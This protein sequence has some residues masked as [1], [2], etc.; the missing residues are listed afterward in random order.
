M[1]TNCWQFAMRL[2][3]F[4]RKVYSFL[5]VLI[6]QSAGHIIP[7][8]SSTSSLSMPTT[9]VHLPTAT[10]NSLLLAR[11]Q[12][13]VDCSASASRSAT[14]AIR[15]ASQS[16]SQAIQQA[17]QSAIQQ[18]QQATISA[19]NAIRDAQNT[20]SQSV[21]QASRSSS[22]IASSASSAV[23]SLQRSADQAIASAK[24]GFH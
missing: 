20:A 10:Y 18:I 1:E 7:G 12:N 4:H 17:S 3:S 22:S 16:A 24:V 5:E 14:E 11:Q 21:A 19:S 23:A 15:Q 6:N 8:A 2:E 13:N 9:T